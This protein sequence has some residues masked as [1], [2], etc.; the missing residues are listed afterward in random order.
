LDLIELLEADVAERGLSVE[1][2]KAQPVLNGSIAE[3]R[4][5]RLAL[6]RLLKEMDLAE[7]GS[8]SQAG[9]DLARA[10]WGAA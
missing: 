4:Q 6:S 10:R 3:L 7:P 5:Q 2:S 1:G 9:K 8:R